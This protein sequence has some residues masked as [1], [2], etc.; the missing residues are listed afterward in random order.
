MTSTETDTRLRFLA[1]ASDTLAVSSPSVSA[2]I[3]AATRDWS[4]LPRTE[5]EYPYNDCTACARHLL[6]GWSCEPVKTPE[7]RQTRKDRI[8]AARIITK[9]VKCSACGTENI[10]QHARRPKT[11]RPKPLAPRKH[12]GLAILSKAEAKAN[13]APT[14]VT[15]PT[16]EVTPPLSK[17]QTPE[18][19]QAKAPGR[20]KARGKNSS[21]QALLANKKPEA[22]QSSGFGLDFMDFMK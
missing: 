4:Q 3:R 1:K 16:Q 7:H 18:P 2:Y 10:I 5:T 8:S 14:P 12:P 15:Q 20:R 19:T 17:G 11:A 9:C 13:R 21:L 6:V 22:P